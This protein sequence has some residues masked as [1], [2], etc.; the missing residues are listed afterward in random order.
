MPCGTYGFVE[1]VIGFKKSKA[2]GAMQPHLTLLVLR[3]EDAVTFGRPL[4]SQNK[5][6][7]A[8]YQDMDSAVP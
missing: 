1:A 2:R 3:S 7:F 8:L 4:L 5:A 6:G